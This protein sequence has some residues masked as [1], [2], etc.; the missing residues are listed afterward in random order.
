MHVRT[1]TRM[2]LPYMSQCVGICACTYVCACMYMHTYICMNTHTHIGMEAYWPA[3]SA[4]SR[5]VDAIFKEHRSKSKCSCAG[6]RG[7]LPNAIASLHVGLSRQGAAAKN[8]TQNLV[9]LDYKT[10]VPAEKL[11]SVHGTIG[12]V[13]CENCGVPYPSAYCVRFTRSPSL[14]R[15]E[16]PSFEFLNQYNS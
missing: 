12:R 14:R 1:H 4:P 10:G 2:N 11:I 8:L 3:R 7:P 6:I 13:E 9:G 15:S 16:L 5:E